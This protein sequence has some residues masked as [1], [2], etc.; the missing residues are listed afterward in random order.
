MKQLKG[1]KSMNRVDRIYDKDSSIKAF[2][3]NYLEYV[4]EVLKKISLD[5]IESFVNILFCSVMISTT[6][7]KSN[8]HLFIYFYLCRM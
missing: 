7:R 3:K 6:T 2:A 4:G 1:K 5:E 8:K